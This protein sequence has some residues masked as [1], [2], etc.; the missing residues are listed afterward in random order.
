MI[1][2]T[3]HIISDVQN[4]PREVQKSMLCQKQIETPIQ[5]KNSC[6]YQLQYLQNTQLAFI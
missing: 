5:P 2:E 1:L 6:E 3:M 4:S